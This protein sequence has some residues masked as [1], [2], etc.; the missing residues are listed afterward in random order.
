MGKQYIVGRKDARKADILI[1]DKTISGRH[2]EL[3]ISSN[4]EISVRDLGSSNGTFI[5]RG[6]KRI[7]ISQQNVSVMSSDI[8]IFGSKSFSVSEFMATQLKG[9]NTENGVTP[10]S[11]DKK[12]YMRCPMCG[13]VTPHG[14]PCVECG[15]RG[16][17]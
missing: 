11:S 8:L 15:Y 13:S 4:N 6:G 12:R 16:D 7:A 9:A 3:S 14:H 5:V 17:K 10:M 1:D 2:A